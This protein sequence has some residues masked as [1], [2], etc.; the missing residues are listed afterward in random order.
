MDFR[1]E[2]YFPPEFREDLT[3]I[4]QKEREMNGID[5]TKKVE[6]SAPP[7]HFWK[8]ILIITTQTLSI[9]VSL[10]TIQK[11]I[12]NK[13]GKVYIT[14][15]GEK[16]DLE[17]YNIDEIRVK[18]GEP[19]LRR[20][21]VNIKVPELEEKEVADNAH[22]LSFRPITYENNPIGRDNHVLWAD[23][24]E[25]DRTIDA[26]LQ[27]KDKTI[28]HEFEKGVSLFATVS[29]SRRREGTPGEFF[30]FT[31]L[32]VSKIKTEGAAELKQEIL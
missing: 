32:N 2:I 27:I 19:K 18:L 12:S 13:K 30:L 11:A 16:I 20:Y 21:K 31:S 3:K 9:I 8:E 10:I 24:N 6:L 26:S 14:S 5:I 15:N 4:I 1:V 29:F 17:A 23:Y 7:E 22:L 25:K 28:N